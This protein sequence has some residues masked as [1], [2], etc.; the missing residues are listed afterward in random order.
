MNK[1]EELYDIANK[2]NIEIK[3]LK[4]E[5]SNGFYLNIC[6]NNL[7]IINKN[8]TNCKLE[9]C[10][11]AEELGHYFVGV[12]PTLIFESDYYI[13]LQRSRNENKAL[14]YAISKLIP[15]NTFKRFYG[16]ELTKFEVAEELGITEEFL[17]RAY[18]ELERNLLYGSNLC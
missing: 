9:V 1:L 2:E 10:T 13:K 15:F 8:I 7:I 5:S 4:L 6:N 16:Q 12:Y 17:E 3:N 11:L 14:K 18:S